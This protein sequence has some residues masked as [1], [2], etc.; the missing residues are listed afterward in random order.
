VVEQLRL[1]LGEHDH[2]PSAV[3]KAFK[4]QASP[5]ELLED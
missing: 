2:A 4:H 3:G 5:Y 1:F